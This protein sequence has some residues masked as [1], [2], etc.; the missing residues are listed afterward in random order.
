MRAGFPV[1]SFGALTPRLYL[2][3]MSAASSR[4][5]DQRRDLREAS[6]WTAILGRTHKMPSLES[7]L[8]EGKA[9]RSPEEVAAEQVAQMR[10]LRMT[11]EQTGKVRSWREWLGQ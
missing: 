6:W 1:E 3:V 7:I 10:V 4:R 2:I 8:A 5:A 11:M 9:E